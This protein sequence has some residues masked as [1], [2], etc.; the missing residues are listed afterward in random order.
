MRKLPEEQLIQKQVDLLE[1]V[2]ASRMRLDRILSNLSSVVFE[3]D[4]EG[5]WTFL[6]EAWEEFVGFTRA[7]S[8]GEN[9]IDYVH[10]DD[11]EENSALFA[12]LIERKKSECRHQVRYLCKGGG[13][14]WVEVHAQL[15][16]DGVDRIVGTTGTLSN[17]HQ[18]RLLMEEKERQDQLL[19]VTQKAGIMFANGHDLIS[20]EDELL[21]ALIEP[22][23]L[24]RAAICN[25]SSVSGR[26]VLDSCRE[27]WLEHGNG[28]ILMLSQ[29]ALLDRYPAFT[30]V[31]DSLDVLLRARLATWDSGE[32]YFLLLPVFA[33]EVACRFILLVSDSPWT[34]HNINALTLLAQG[35]GLT[36]HRNMMLHA[37]SESESRMKSALE[38]S[39]EGVWDWNIPTGSV[40]F[41]PVWLGMLGYHE[42][43]L[44]PDVSTWE[45]LL[46]P[47]DLSVVMEALNEH[48]LGRVA[49]YQTT[50]RLKHKDGSWRWILDRG[51][52]VEWDEGGQPLRAI[53]THLDVT[54][55]KLME[56]KL[57]RRSLELASANDEIDAVL[58]VSPVGFVG[59]GDDGC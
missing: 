47:D 9:F 38:N 33:G 29:Q 13:F 12:P 40:Y 57:A 21:Q 34:A 2:N 23:R 49:H 51:K 1:K 15:L 5:R 6:N 50:H 20:K 36:L 7:E 4:A 28:S 56:E 52:V 35:Y 55:T 10:P 39:N 14:V 37:I 27:M 31:L 48:L 46:H 32:E 19:A 44:K 43:D 18:E 59:F 42:G 3:T 25:C 11:R 53:G 8:I 22:A 45:E 54:E 24:T 16:L 17:V 26:V 41:S 30:C 58:M